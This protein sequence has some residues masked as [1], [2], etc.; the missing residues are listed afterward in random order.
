V[1]HAGPADSWSYQ[2]QRLVKWTGCWMV[3]RHFRPRTLWT[4]DISAL[5]PKCPDISALVLKWHQGRQFSTG[6][7]WTHSGPRHRKEDG[8]ACV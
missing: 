7:H 6:Q 1:E 4:Q 2:P 3:S 5:V 8:C